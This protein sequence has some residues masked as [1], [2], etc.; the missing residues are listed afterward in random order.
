MAIVRRYWNSPVFKI[1]FVMLLIGTV[2]LTRHMLER[3]TRLDAALHSY[4]TVMTEQAIAMATQADRDIAAGK[5]RGPLH[6]VPIGVKDLKDFVP[7]EDATVVTKIRE[8]GG[9]L[10]AWNKASPRA[11]DFTMPMNMAGTPAICLPCGYATDGVPYSIQ[12][13]GRRLSEPMLCRI[14][15]AYERET[16]WHT[17][18][19]NIRFA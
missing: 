16:T 17:R 2:E 15:S 7:A 8:A 11:G 5:R 6:G 1:G 9:V 4:A 19:P 12:F 10:L 14:A 3:I 13:A 18:H